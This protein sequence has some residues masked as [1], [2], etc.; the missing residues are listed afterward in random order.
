MLWRR[1]AGVAVALSAV[2]GCVTTAATGPSVR[3][4]QSDALPALFS[5]GTEQSRVETVP[6]VD[7][8]EWRDCAESNVPDGPWQCASI[9]VPMDYRHPATSRRLSI[10]LTR[11]PATDTETRIGSLVLN[12]GG[13]GGSG[14]D[15]AWELAAELPSTLTSRFDL[16]GFDPRGVGRSTPVDCIPGPFGDATCRRTERQLLSFLGTANVARD[17]ETIREAVGDDQLTYL[18]FS[19]GTALG[20]IYADMFPSSVRAMVLDGSIDPG[21]GR[22]NTDGTSIGAPHDPFYGTQDFA[23]TLAIFHELCDATRRCGAG[24]SS[25][26]TLDRVQRIVDGEPVR[27][28]SDIGPIDE[29]DLGD[30]VQQSMYTIDVWPALGIALRDA[31]DGDASTLAALESLLTFGYP[32]TLGEEIRPRASQAIY[33]ADFAGRSG[34]FAVAECDGVPESAEPLAPVTATTTTTPIVVIGT[35]GDPATPGY[36]AP[37]MAKALVSAVAVRWEGAGHTALLHSS[38]IDT[39]VVEYLVSLAV[40]EDHTDC[41]FTA[42]G[43][44]TV[45]RA[46]RVFTPDRALVEHNLTEVYRGEGL[47]VAEAVCVAKGVAVTGSVAQLVYARLGVRRPEY[48]LLRHRV[49]AACGVR[50]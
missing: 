18:G 13:P 3:A 43:N 40:P 47:D 48:E 12:P 37:R 14:V 26:D 7:A 49:E 35:D 39:I 41:P 50:G 1:L 32:A 23:G 15:L 6:D 27:Y 20:A 4:H 19:Y 8:V 30:I 5:R 22:Y 21:A 24:P 28:F 33:C 17:V 36:L 11:L 31:A 9:E 2:S 44:S 45:A 25:A 42:S 16:V 34:R 10:A 29:R 38:C 46:A